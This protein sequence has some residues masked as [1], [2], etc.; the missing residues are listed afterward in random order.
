MLINAAAVSIMA[1]SAVHVLTFFLAGM[2][3]FF[4]LVIAGCILV[5]GSIDAERQGKE[6][7]KKS[8]ISAWQMA[9]VGIGL[10]YLSATLVDLAANEPSTK[11]EE[12]AQAHH[13]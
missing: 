12:E 10:M 13:E 6:E 9:I 7:Q 3:G 8:R 5:F 4:V 11:S 2:V 1:V